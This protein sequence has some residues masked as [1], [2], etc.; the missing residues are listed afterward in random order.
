MGYSTCSILSQPPNNA[1]NKRIVNNF[2]T[3][4]WRELQR[5][6]EPDKAWVGKKFQEFKEKIEEVLE[7][8]ERASTSISGG[9]PEPCWYENLRREKPVADLLENLFVAS[10]G[11]EAAVL[12]PEPD[13]S[14]V[15]IRIQRC[16][17]PSHGRPHRVAPI[18][19][20]SFAL[21]KSV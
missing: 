14:T 17:C 9:L 13:L 10:K 18:S 20:G 11:K 3:S 15:K 5:K 4:W 7:E 1:A 8:E 21:G 12:L 6:E 16:D 19:Y 2:P